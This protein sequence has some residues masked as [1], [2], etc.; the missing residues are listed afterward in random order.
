MMGVLV[1]AACSGGIIMGWNPWPC[2]PCMEPGTGPTPFAASLETCTY[3]SSCIMHTLTP[4][5]FGIWAASNRTCYVKL[6][7]IM[8]SSSG[9]SMGNL[10]FLWQD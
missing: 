7:E 2:C 3:T 8:S 9:A 10:S 6:W 5:A 4:R 1:M